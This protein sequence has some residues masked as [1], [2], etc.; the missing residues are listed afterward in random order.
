VNW[1]GTVTRTDADGVYVQIPQ[2]G[3]GIEFG[4]CQAA[5]GF[6]LVPGDAVVVASIGPVKDDL[7]V[8][9]KL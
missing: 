3:D 9:T 8:T 1:R 2:L 7:V 6:I 5:V 4:P